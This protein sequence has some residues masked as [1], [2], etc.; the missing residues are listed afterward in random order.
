[1]YIILKKQKP[2][3]KEAKKAVFKIN[4]INKQVFVDVEKLS[5]LGLDISNKSYVAFTDLLAPS[6]IKKPIITIAF[7]DKEEPYASI[8]FNKKN[9]FIN[10]FFVKRLLSESEELTCN[11]N[12]TIFLE[13]FEEDICICEYGVAIYNFKISI[14]LKKVKSKTV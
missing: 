14:K 10:S 4:A 9:F 11:E 6:L 3:K 5:E 2:A 7:L 8:P 13:I 12:E 1:M